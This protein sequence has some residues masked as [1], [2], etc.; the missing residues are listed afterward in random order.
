MLEVLKAEIFPVISPAKKNRPWYVSIEG[1]SISFAI[2]YS[3]G[4]QRAPS[5]PLCT[6]ALFGQP[7]SPESTPRVT[8]QWKKRGNAIWILS[9]KTTGRLLSLSFSFPC[10]KEP[11]QIFVRDSVP[12]IE[13][14][15]EAPL[16]IATPATL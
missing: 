13:I 3:R 1:A 2:H 16:W 11:R 12:S 4:A 14:R 8:K 5:G 9:R 6:S 7:K 15:S 10:H